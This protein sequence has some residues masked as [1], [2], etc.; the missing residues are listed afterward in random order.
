MRHDIIKLN[1][2]RPQLAQLSTPLVAHRVVLLKDLLPGC[3]LPDL[4]LLAPSLLLFD[5]LDATVGHA[6]RQLRA[7]MPGIPVES[8]LHHGGTVFWSFFGL[9]PSNITRQV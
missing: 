7:L 5:D 8:K 2:R 9:L 6:I 3:N 4:L 1:R